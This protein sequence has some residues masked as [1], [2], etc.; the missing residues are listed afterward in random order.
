MT[1]SPFVMKKYFVGKYCE[2]ISIS[3]GH[4]IL[5]PSPPFP[6]SLTRILVSHFIQRIII[7][8]SYDLF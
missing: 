3:H 7:C 8:Y 5:S 4:Q 6:P 2:T 1:P